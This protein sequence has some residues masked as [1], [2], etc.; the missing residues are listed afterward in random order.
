MTPPATRPPPPPPNASAQQP[1]PVPQHSLSWLWTMEPA[2]KKR[3]RTKAPRP[4]PRVARD[5]QATSKSARKKQRRQRTAN[6]C[7]NVA[8]AFQTEGIREHV[9]LLLDVESVEAYVAFL[10]ELGSSSAHRLVRDEALWS[11][12]LATHF[13]TP[14][15]AT[16]QSNTST[17]MR[18]RC[19]MQQSKSH[20]M[21][22]LLRDASGGCASLV[23][24][25]LW[26]QEREW[27]G[28]HVEIIMSNSFYTPHVPFVEFEDRAYEIRNFGSHGLAI[29]DPEMSATQV[30]NTQVRCM[31]H[32]IDARMAAVSPWES[33][34][35]SFE[36]ALDVI[37]R[38]RRLN[39]AVVAPTSPLSAGVGATE[40]AIAATGL[41]TIKQFA[42]Q[43]DWSA[44]IGIVCYEKQRFQAFRVEKQRLLDSF[45]CG[46]SK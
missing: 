33:L 34:S 9:L 5:K 19:K 44:R 32:V 11:Q 13:K 28:Q 20:V 21:D 41:L 27:F 12:M 37:Q 15:N 16:D 4:T 36:D 14:R 46:V 38:E 31:I 6:Q 17:L 26:S 22:A 18:T 10:S 43:Q 7:E 35:R 2:F 29:V 42:I 24:F 45:G 8:R 25:L 3:S 23:Q 1:P 39:V 30:S 40:N